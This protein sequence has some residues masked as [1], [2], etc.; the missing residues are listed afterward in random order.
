MDLPG[1]LQRFTPH[2]DTLWLPLQETDPGTLTRFA[3]AVGWALRVLQAQR[4]S[5]PEMRRVL[6]SAMTGLEG[7]SEEQAGQWLRTA[8]YLMLFTYHR[9]SEPELLDLIEERARQSK[10]RF[11]EEVF[12]VRA[13]LAEIERERGEAQG[14]ARGRALG[15]AEATRRA[16]LTVL[17]RR[18][19]VLPPEIEAA[20]AAA[21]TETMTAWLEVAATASSL[22]DVGITSPS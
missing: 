1:S 17:T 2:W 11:R 3:S 19:G 22:T 4:A 8:W 9:R 18:F 20:V 15:E 21:S 10:F 5:L 13:T 7:L 12:H 16:L 6:D 14:E